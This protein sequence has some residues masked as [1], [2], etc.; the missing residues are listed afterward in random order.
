MSRPYL[1]PEYITCDLKIFGNRLRVPNRFR[2]GFANQLRA[3]NFSQLI[4]GGSVENQILTLT[5]D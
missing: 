4:V 5:G 1:K 2:I 3:C